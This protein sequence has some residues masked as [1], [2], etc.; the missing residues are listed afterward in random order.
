M[1]TPNELLEWAITNVDPRDDAAMRAAS[2]RLSALQQNREFFIDALR[3]ELEIVGGSR[4]G[5]SRM[6]SSQAFNFGVRAREDTSFIIRCALWTPVVARNQASVDLTNKVYSYLTPHN[7]NFSLLTIG[8]YGPGYETLIYDYARD[9]SKGHVGEQVD[10]RFR[11]R[12]RLEEGKIIYFKPLVDV[13]TQLHPVGV[14]VSLNLIGEHTDHI[15]QAQHEFDLESSRIQGLLNGNSVAKQMI[16]FKLAAE[17]AVG[18]EFT[19]L[20]E[21]I[22]RK[23]YSEHVR[24]ES[25]R[26]LLRVASNDS[27]RWKAVSAEDGHPYVRELLTV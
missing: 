19:D 20:L 2:G 3:T 14:S 8:Y 5:M 23:H 21:F 7:H 17:L 10:L 27:E 22:A 12:T 6:T 1:M 15:T 25:I 13:H 26:T 24:A 11:E 4:N 9:R 18:D 16:A